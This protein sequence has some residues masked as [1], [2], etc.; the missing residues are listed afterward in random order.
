MS[1]YL[2]LCQAVARDSG[3]VSDLTAPSTVA[4][5]TGRLLRIVN[6]TAEAYSDIQRKRDDW[7]WL[8]REFDGETLATV[9]RYALNLTTERFKHWVFESE[10]GN[11]TFS[12]YKTS[13]G[14]ST[15][16]WLRYVPWDEFRRAYL[17]GPRADDTGKPRV[18][19]VDPAAQLVFYPIPDAVYTIRGEFYRGPQILAAN[20]DVPE[21]PLAHHD[22]IKWQALILLG[23][24]DEAPDQIPA[25]AAFLGEHMA[26][27]VRKQTPRIRLPGPLA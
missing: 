8:R 4:S 14:Q 11:D 20:A 15:E 25:W 24:F 17:F 9:Q 2:E 27:L 1:S 7:R 23:V 21:M 26:A 18:I 12:I 13:E 16:G 22:A 10:D 5:Q 3:T 6:W 19:S